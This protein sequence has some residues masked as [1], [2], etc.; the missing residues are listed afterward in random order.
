MIRVAGVSK[1]DDRVAHRRCQPGARRVQA[2]DRYF[3]S[4]REEELDIH[5]VE[6][7]ELWQDLAYPVE[8]VDEDRPAPGLGECLGEPQRRDQ[9]LA[10]TP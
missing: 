1:G 6:G 3:F 5:V 7:A 4:R 10:V 2:G 9:Q 8:A